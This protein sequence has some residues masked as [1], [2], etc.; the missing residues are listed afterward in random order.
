MRSLGQSPL[1]IYRVWP[2]RLLSSGLPALY[3]LDFFLSW[4]FLGAKSWVFMH[5]VF[6]VEGIQKAGFGCPSAAPP[7]LAS[8]YDY[9]G[10]QQTVRRLHLSLVVC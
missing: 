9:D 8:G 10:K 4:M 3:R 2:P 1:T 7:Q 5:G 6:V